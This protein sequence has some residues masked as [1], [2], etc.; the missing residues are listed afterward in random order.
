M[1]PWSHWLDTVPFV[2]LICMALHE[3]STTPSERG[4]PDVRV[5]AQPLHELTHREL[6]ES[7]VLLRTTLDATRDALLAIDEHGRVTLV[8]QRFEQ[9]W[10]VG[11]DPLS[12]DALP[13]MRERLL[14]QVAEP[15]A[16]RD[17]LDRLRGDPEAVHAGRLELLDGRV[18]DWHS[19]PS[20]RDGRP[21]GRLYSFVDVTEQANADRALQQRLRLETS[22]A[23]IAAALTSPG[24]LDLDGVL[25]ELG[26]AVSVHRTYIMHFRADGVTS[27]NTHEWCA[28]GVHPEID[29][30]QGIDT[31]PLTW[32]WSAM[33]KGDPVVINDISA[34]PPEAAIEQEFLGAQGIQSLLAL[35]MISREHGLI[36]FVG[37]DDVRR[38]RVWND[39]DLRALRVVSDL[40]AAELDRRRAA[41]ALRA[42]EERLTGGGAV[43]HGVADDDRLLGQR[44]GIRR[45]L[46]HQLAALQVDAV[47]VAVAGVVRMFGARLAAE[48]LEYHITH[49]QPQ[50]RLIARQPERFAQHLGA[51]E[52]RLLSVQ[53][54]GEQ[55]EHALTEQRLVHFGRWCR[56]HRHRVVFGGPGDAERPRFAGTELA[57][58][59]RVTVAGDG[60]QMHHV[61]GQ[62]LQRVADTLGNRDLPLA[63]ER[64]RH[65]GPRLYYCDA[66]W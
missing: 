64:R 24:E 56:L 51:Y 4:S 31:S 15:Q 23:R 48:T 65:E 2:F 16:V 10:Q 8:N 28:E 26:R 18:V 32:W 49:C 66:S 7:L 27:D 62:Q 3:S 25:G 44:P 29:N 9:L 40:L 42:S 21:V 60:P 54:F 46:D 12:P 38:P 35:P 63:R 37:Y 6:V 39:D 17:A 53:L 59:G 61:A 11:V 57:G 19:R 55:Q 41:E 52:T 50:P 36:G 43:E 13:L 47:L 20:L 34:L 30:L 14:A 22:I 1:R 45:G 58:G 5:L 33:G